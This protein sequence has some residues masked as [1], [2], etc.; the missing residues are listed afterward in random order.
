MKKFVS[1]LAG[2][3]MGGLVG[4]TLVLLLTPISGDVLREQISETFERFQTELKQAA[5]NKRSELESQLAE[6]RKPHSAED[7]SIKI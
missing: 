7:S 6:L 2:S 4:A 1:F 3:I 5:S